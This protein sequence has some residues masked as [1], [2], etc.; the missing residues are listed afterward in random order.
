MQRTTK[1][2]SLQFHHLLPL[3]SEMVYSVLVLVGLLLLKSSTKFL[4]SRWCK[5]APNA[6]L[7]AMPW[8]ATK[9]GWRW[10]ATAGR[11]AKAKAKAKQVAKEEALRKAAG[12]RCMVGPSGFARSLSGWCSKNFGD[13]QRQ[14]DD[15]VVIRAAVLC[16][17]LLLFVLH[18]RISGSGVDI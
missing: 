10:F 5:R 15:W 14:L 11:R 12:F 16:M 4:T 8:K 6:R 2:L 13:T 17:A 1:Y 7:K 18:I 3:Q 9:R